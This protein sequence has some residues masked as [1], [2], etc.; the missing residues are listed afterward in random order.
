MAGQLVKIEG[1]I[2]SGN[3]AIKG[4]ILKCGNGELGALVSKVKGACVKINP[5]ASSFA[6]TIDELKRLNFENSQVSF[7]GGKLTRKAGFKVGNCDL[8]MMDSSGKPVKVKDKD[9]RLTKRII[10]DNKVAGYCVEFMGKTLKLDINNIV[11]LSNIFKPVDYTIAVRDGIIRRK[12]PSTGKVV[13]TTGKKSYLVGINGNRLSELPE[14]VIAN[15]K[16][17]KESPNSEANKEAKKEKKSKA[18]IDTTLNIKPY[19]GKDRLYDF[20]QKLSIAG[21]ALASV[22]DVGYPMP[23]GISSFGGLEVALPKLDSCMNLTIKITYKRILVFTDGKNKAIISRGHDR[24]IFDK[25]KMVGSLTV[26]C[27]EGSL[28]RLSSILDIGSKNPL[29]ARVAKVMAKVL[30]S[31]FKSD[32]KMYYINVDIKNMK[33]GSNTGVSIDKVDDDTL[34]SIIFNYVRYFKMWDCA[35]NILSTSYVVDLCNDKSLKGFDKSSIDKLKKCG[36]RTADLTIDY[37]K[38]YGS[39]QF[40]IF[41]YADILFDSHDKARGVSDII[42]KVRGKLFKKGVKYSTVKAIMKKIGDMALDDIA[43]NVKP[44]SLAYPLN[45]KAC[46]FAC[47]FEVGEAIAICYFTDFFRSTPSDE[48]GTRYL[49]NFVN[50]CKEKADYYSLLIN[51]MFVRGFKK[52]GKIHTGGKL[53]DDGDDHYKF[54]I[55]SE[56]ELD[57]VELHSPDVKIVD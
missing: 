38:S 41:S 29:D 18:F 7:A 4:M 46:G 31:E 28:D 43:E 34:G 2:L 30:G 8:Y 36:V 24:F 54:N 27:S 45:E 39:I 20:M 11:M 51:E 10:V 3:Y 56:Y 16:P 14:E 32:S 47:D 13:E 12:D 57:D 50:E 6:F 25:L 53:V 52:D 55:N 15:A 5:K 19:T 48:V 49:I 40:G 22:D 21:C 9:I 23:D 17:K 33:F 1:V 42:E 44:K 26:V 37:T 35:E